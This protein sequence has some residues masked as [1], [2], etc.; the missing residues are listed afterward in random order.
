MSIEFNKGW[1]KTYDPEETLVKYNQP[2][3]NDEESESEEVEEDDQET[4]QLHLPSAAVSDLYMLVPG[5]VQI[6]ET[7]PIITKCVQALS[8]KLDP[9]FVENAD[10]EMQRV[11][12]NVVTDIPAGIWK[13]EPYDLRWGSRAL[14]D[15]CKKVM[16]LINEKGVFIAFCSETQFYYLQKNFEQVD[17]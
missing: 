5:S 2:H 15:F 13:T 7:W 3:E 1:R 14:Y 4:L 10:D 9:M 6:N 11:Q 17:I 12:V 16:E 8:K